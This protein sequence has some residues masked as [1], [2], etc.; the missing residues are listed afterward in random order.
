MNRLKKL[1]LLTSLILTWTL[2]SSGIAQQVP[3][4]PRRFM[5]GIAK[6]EQT[7]RGP[8]IYYNPATCRR[9]GPEVCSF[10]RAHE[11]AHIQLNHLNRNIP[12]RQ[13]EAEADMY[14]ARMVPRSTAA[15]AQR[16]FRRGNAGGID[17]G[18][19]WQRARRV[20]YSATGSPYQIRR[21]S[22]SR[23][24]YPTRTA[25]SAR[26]MLNSRSRGFANP[27]RRI[28]A[29]NRGNVNPAVYSAPGQAYTN[30]PFGYSSS[31]IARRR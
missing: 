21:N 29:L 28:Y 23:Q 17:H 27:S 8:V 16:Y 13:A 10:F 20:G 6:V 11:Y 31:R 2:T 9:L 1:G 3:E 5:R 4:I 25:Y 12:V 26:G 30:R 15:A 7:A 18:S 19:A 22:Y 24:T 14:A